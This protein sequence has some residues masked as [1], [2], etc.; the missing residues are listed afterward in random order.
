MT[1]PY[2]AFTSK[3]DHLIVAPRTV[4]Q[5]DKMSIWL[6]SVEPD[7]TLLCY[8]GNDLF[9]WVASQDCMMEITLESGETQTHKIPAGS[10]PAKE[11]RFTSQHAKSMKNISNK[12]QKFITVEYNR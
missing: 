11:T 1:R 12:T 9:L 4:S 5:T 7:E 3:Q 6:I 2:M 8:G 10:Y